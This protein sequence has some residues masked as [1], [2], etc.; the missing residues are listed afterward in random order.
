[1]G[2]YQTNLFICDRCGESVS[3]SHETSVF[4]DPIVM[5]PMNP[6]WE[7]MYI[8]GEEQLCCVECLKSVDR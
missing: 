6:L 1:M 2:I 4:S 5:L 3:L 7:F 8:D